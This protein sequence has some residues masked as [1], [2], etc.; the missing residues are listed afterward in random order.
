MMLPK[1][2][3]IMGP[4]AIDLDWVNRSHKVQG[5]VLAQYFVITLRPH[6]MGRFGETPSSR[7][8]EHLLYMA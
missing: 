5:R 7:D 6:Q 4:F 2:S 1:A 3:C 8:R